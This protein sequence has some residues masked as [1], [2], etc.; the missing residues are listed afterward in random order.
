VVRGA[1]LVDS[2]PRQLLLAHLLG[3]PAVTR[4]AHVPLVLGSDGRRL[5][6][7]H[8][9]VTLAERS[10]LGER[11]GEILGWMAR[12]LGLGEIGKTPPPAD[13]LARFAPGHLPL[14]PT[15]ASGV[16]MSDTSPK[17]ATVFTTHPTAGYEA[18][19]RGPFSAESNV[20]GAGPTNR[21]TTVVGDSAPYE[22]SSS[23]AKSPRGLR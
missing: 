14:E 20:A 17:L 3:L 2:T 11:P 22:G 8:G 18:P 6:K 19:G 4:Y 23:R 21:I 13:L 9:A 16:S 5:A 10:V 12:S 15:S 7:R 1:D